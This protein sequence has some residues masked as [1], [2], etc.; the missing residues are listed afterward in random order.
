MAAAV[1]VALKSLAKPRARLILI[2]STKKSFEENED[3]IEPK[4]V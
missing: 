3:S 4:F 2:P 1:N